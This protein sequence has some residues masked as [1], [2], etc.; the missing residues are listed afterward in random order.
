MEE[1]KTPRNNE[2]TASARP[3]DKKVEVEI[4]PFRK[5]RR[6]FRRGAKIAIIIAIILVV[7]AAGVGFFRLRKSSRPSHSQTASGNSLIDQYKNE[8]GELQ[9]KA[10]S[11]KPAD[12]QNYA[13]AQYAT[14][15]AQGA[16]QT[17]TQLVRSGSAS[18]VVYNNLA[19]ALRDQK[20]YTQAIK[21]YQTAIGKDKTL[22]SAYFNLGSVYQYNL[23]QP[24]KAVD[25]YREGI[26]NN[27]TSADLEVF[28][29]QAYEQQKDTADAVSAYQAA[30]KIQ[31]GNAA[32][33]AG[34][35]RLGKKT[36]E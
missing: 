21:D 25:V 13:V 29:G 36:L 33:K 27:P 24:A 20:N 11:G 16:A 35:A 28:L 15:N 3:E 12:L 18:A 26:K 9:K 10:Q 8:L 23:N 6:S 32:A 1:K 17:Y 31:S 19:N 4:R 14:G 22:L 34:L 5:G 30:L 7:V 2:K